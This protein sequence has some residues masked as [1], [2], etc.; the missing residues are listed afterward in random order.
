MLV[1]PSSP[2]AASV[3]PAL[4]L[5]NLPAPNRFAP[6]VR[7]TTARQNRCMGLLAAG[8]RADTA[9]IGGSGPV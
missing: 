8:F 6:W 3:V 4:I 9:R 1:S 7:V 2:A 5:T